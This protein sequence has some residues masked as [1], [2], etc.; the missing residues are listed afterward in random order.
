MRTNRDQ[1]HAV[2]F[3]AAGT[4]IHLRE[5]VGAGY[6]R[7]A[8]RHGMDL[9]PAATDA[10]FRSAWQAMPPMGSALGNNRDRSE[11]LWWRTIV[12]R[13]LDQFPQTAAASA[14]DRDAYFD[15]LFD[16]Y[17][18]PDAWL[19]FPEVASVLDTLNHHG[20]RLFV[21]S[22]FDA[23]LLAVLEGLRLSQHFEEVFY[24]G[25]IGHAKPSPEIFDHA[26]AGI[27]LPASDCLHVGDDPDADWQGA[28]DAGLAAIELDRSNHDLRMVLE[29]LKLPQLPDFS[30]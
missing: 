19:P 30:D 11:K 6:S 15:E 25:S 8:S 14:S 21:L 13:V 16:S 17:A 29:A 28:R 24:S 2:L 10:A 9:D 4:L 7:V 12:D 20:L 1:I 27:G 18:S 3:D 5:S 22:N 23:R 26:L